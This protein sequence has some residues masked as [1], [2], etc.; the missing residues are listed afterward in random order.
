MKF[1]II[2]FGCQMNV[3]DS[4]WLCLALRKRGYEFTSNPDE[5]DFVLFNT[6][7]VRQ[8]PEQKVYSE[9]GRLRSIWRK[10]A[11]FFVGIG[12]CVAQQVGM[13]F[14]ERF[15]YVRLVFGTDGI[16]MVPDVIGQLIVYPQ[17]KISLISFEEFYPEREK[18]FPEKAPAS[19]FINIMQGCD[20]FCAYCIVPFTRGRQKSRTKDAVLSECIEFVERGAK[21]IVLLGQNVNSY[22]QD[23]FGDGTSFVE[24][25]KDVAKIKGLK[26]LRFTTSHP[27]D[28]SKEL[29]YLFGELDV[30]CPHLHLPLQVGSNKILKKMGRKYTREKYLSLVEQ[31]RKIRPDMA[32]STDLI[33]GFP[34]ETRDDFE[35]T[36]DMLRLIEFE[37][38]YSFKYSDRPGTRAEKMANKVPEPE[39]Q[40][41]LVELQEL[42]EKITQ[43]KY[44]ARVGEKEEILLENV[45]FDSKL[46][47]RTFRGRDLWNRVVNVQ[48]DE[49]TLACELVH[50]KIVE[51]KKHSLLG[52]VL[53]I[54]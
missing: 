51:A 10:N 23:K 37:N 26:R 48:I 53:N 43:K 17:K 1:S 50:V 13:G 38:A 3:A 46:E 44:M 34:G 16:Y 54:L 41:R 14:F 18:V 49:Q 31:L 32:F 52:K 24:L 9:V 40:E 12:G 21:E 35:Q 27:K 29:I 11:N 45:K 36:L 30:L 28:L 2:T 8:K 15:P 39:K 6:C 33:V 22:G 7:S 19:V 42:Q 20:N 47:N 4:N 5:A 25:L